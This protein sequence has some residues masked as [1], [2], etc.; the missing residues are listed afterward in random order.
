[1]RIALSRDDTHLF[2]RIRHKKIVGAI[3][4]GNAGMS[5]RVL[6]LDAG[7]DERLGGLSWSAS[8]NR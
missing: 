4:G 6:F 2:S 5:A 7:N 8:K 3:N 1:V